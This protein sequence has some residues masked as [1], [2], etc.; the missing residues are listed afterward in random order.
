LHHAPVAEPVATTAAR[1]L[2]ARR[3]RTGRADS[4]RWIGSAALTYAHEHVGHL[5]G[6]GG[7]VG[8]E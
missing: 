8:H 1:L 6:F 7:R 2:G 4:Q 3:D 5:I